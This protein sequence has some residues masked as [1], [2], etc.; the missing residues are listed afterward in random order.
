M[1]SHRIRTIGNYW[2]AYRPALIARGGSG[3]GATVPAE[4]LDCGLILDDELARV[5]AGANEQSTPQGLP[6]MTEESFVVLRQ[7]LVT[8][9]EVGHTLGLRSQLGV[10]H[11][12]PRVGHGVSVAAPD[13][14]GEQPDRSARRLSARG[15]RVRRHDGPLL[16]HA[17]RGRSRSRRAR[18]PSSPRR[19]RRDCCSRPDSIRAGIATTIWPTRP[20]IFARPWRSGGS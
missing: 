2:D 17:V 6:R 13:D 9:H 11:Q 12:R 15:R 16:V 7:T 3:G 14:H 18:R 20:N 19:A 10:E 8:A 4:A 1:D 5:I